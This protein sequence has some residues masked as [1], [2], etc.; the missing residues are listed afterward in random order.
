MKKFI[1]GGTFAAALVLG[2]AYSYNNSNAGLSDLQ[3][4]NVEALANNPEGPH[5]CDLT[6]YIDGARESWEESTTGGSIS[7]SG[8]ISLG[9]ASSS[10]SSSDGAWYDEFVAM[11]WGFISKKPSVDIGLEGHWETTLIPICDNDNTSC[12]AKSWLKESPRKL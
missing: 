1:L 6:I 10:S 2:A 5:G 11:V 12:C 8:N 9:G 4:A 7:A 3:A